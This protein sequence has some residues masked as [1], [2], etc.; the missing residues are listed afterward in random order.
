MLAPPEND[1]P[2]YVHTFQPP[3]PVPIL[4]GD[5]HPVLD[6]DGDPVMRVPVLP[7]FTF[8]FMPLDPD[9]VAEKRATANRRYWSGPSKFDR[10]ILR[11][12]R[13]KF[14]H[15]GLAPRS[16]LDERYRRRQINRRRRR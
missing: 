12:Y 14:R 5:G 16:V 10:Q 8:E 11:A 13:V 3:E 9:P 1:G 2:P 7:S 6:E 15:L 4:G